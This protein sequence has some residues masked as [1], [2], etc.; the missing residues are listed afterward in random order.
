MRNHLARIG[1][2][3]A[4]VAAALLLRGRKAAGPG[5]D[6]PDTP[7]QCVNALFD[8]AARGDDEAYLAVV[9]G[10]L[11]RTLRAVRDT[12]AE[13][14]RRNLRRSADG[15]LALALSRR[16]DGPAP[17]VALDV[18]IVFADRTERQRVVASP[19]SGGWAVTALGPAATTRPAVPYGTPVY[20]ATR[21]QGTRP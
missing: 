1:V 14:F 21:T 8:A 16:D 4:L 7:E 2:I 5:G 6:L 10:E 12:D 3:A 18:E 9:R 13:A 11:A 20:E 17:H 15:V 19:E